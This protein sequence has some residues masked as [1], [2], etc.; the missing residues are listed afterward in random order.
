[1]TQIAQ[2][3]GSICFQ[4]FLSQLRGVPVNPH[5]KRVQNMYGKGGVESQKCLVISNFQ[6]VPRY[7]KRADQK[8]PITRHFW[9]PTPLCHTYSEPSWHEDSPRPPVAGS[10]MHPAMPRN[11]YFSSFGQLWVIKSP[12]YYLDSKPQPTSPNFVFYVLALFCFCILYKLAF[13]F[14]LVFVVA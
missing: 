4:A 6:S 2:N 7:R 5:V 12:P 8:P 3:L 9:L 1:M 11:I 14:V 10:K 13:V